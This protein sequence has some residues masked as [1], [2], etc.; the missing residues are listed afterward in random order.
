VKFSSPAAA[1]LW[2]Q[3]VLIPWRSG[4]AFDP[5]P[6]QFRGGTGSMGAIVTAIAI[7]TRA[8]RACCGAG[9]C[10]QFNRE[11]F[12][13]FWLPEPTIVQPRR[14]SAEIE[15]IESCINTFD[16]L[17]RNAGFIE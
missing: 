5:D 7:D 3:G 15:R 9:R 10:P 17:L 2:A 14:S 13:A 1:Y 4:K 16:R 8:E 12:L 6:E 11:C